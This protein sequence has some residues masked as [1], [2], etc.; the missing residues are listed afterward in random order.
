MCCTS[1]LLLYL[2]ILTE[3][4]P[5]AIPAQND[6]TWSWPAQIIVIFLRKIHR[7]L[8]L[9][10]PGTGKCPCVFPVPDTWSYLLFV[11]IF[12]MTFTVIHGQTYLWDPLLRFFLSNITLF[13]NTPVCK[14]IQHVSAYIL[15]KHRRCI[16]VSVKVVWIAYRLPPVPTEAS[17]VFSLIRLPF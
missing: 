4:W 9:Q 7:Y 5:N 8:H 13:Y 10:L 3:P 17:N 14:I 6:D 12:P 16:V 15:Q 11:L 2:C 1:W